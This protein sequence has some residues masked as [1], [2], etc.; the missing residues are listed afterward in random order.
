MS[1]AVDSIR[2]LAGSGSAAQTPPAGAPRPAGIAQDDAQ[3]TAPATG[4]SRAHETTQGGID[5]S[6]ISRPTAPKPT[7]P[8]VS[9]LLPASAHSL[10]GVPT[11]PASHAPE[12][13]STLSDIDGE[14]LDGDSLDGR[15][16][17][18]P[19]GAANQVQGGAVKAVETESLPKADFKR[20]QRLFES[21]SEEEDDDKDE[22]DELMDEDDD[23][24]VASASAVKLQKRTQPKPVN[25]SNATPGP[26]RQQQAA[27]TPRY[28]TELVKNNSAKNRHV[29]RIAPG[30]SDGLT[31]TWPKNT[32]VDGMIGGKL[33]WHR[34]IARGETKDVMW[35]EKIGDNLAQQLN[36][37]SGRRQISSASHSRS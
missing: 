18:I 21:S 11:P 15:P 27:G 17:A 16:M 8:A 23:P 24:P 34:A 29:I 5:P 28:T 30:I 36:V 33:N 13:T 1:G 25:H 10:L 35:R 20:K 3:G 6:L 22:I 2:Q 9:P 26:S 7:T 14:S 32:Q 31:S 37:P 12:S 19:H 4:P